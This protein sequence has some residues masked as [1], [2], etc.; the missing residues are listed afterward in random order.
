MLSR[1]PATAASDRPHPAAHAQRGRNTPFRV[2]RCGVL[3]PLDA[4]AQMGEP[5]QTA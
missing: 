5:A 1:Y 4:V 2:W 3:R